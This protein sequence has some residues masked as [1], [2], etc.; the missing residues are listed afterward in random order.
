VRIKVFG[1]FGEQVGGIQGGVEGKE[2]FA[3]GGKTFLKD[4]FDEDAKAVFAAGGQK[5]DSAGG[6]QVEST[7]E[8]AS[9]LSGPFGDGADFT[10]E[11]AEE[12]ENLAGFRVVDFA[13]ANG[14]VLVFGH[15]ES[16]FGFLGK[17]SDFNFQAID[18]PGF[19][20]EDGKEE[21]FEF[22]GVAFFGDGS[23]TGE[24]ES[25]ESL[26]VLVFGEIQFELVVELIHM[27]AGIHFVNGIG[28]FDEFLFGG[29]FVF[30]F[31]FSDQLFDDVLNGDNTRRAAIFIQNNGNVDFLGLEIVEE[32]P[33]GF[34]FGNEEG[35]PDDFSKGR[36]AVGFVESLE[37]VFGVEHPDDGVDGLF[38]HG[39]AGMAVLQDEIDGFLEVVL[40]AEA[41]HFGAG[42]HN[43]I[44]SSVAEIEDGFNHVPL[45]LIDGAF[46]FL[47][48]DER[49][50]FL[51]PFLDAFFFGI[52]EGDSGEPPDNIF[53]TVHE[54][55][56]RV[57]EGVGQADGQIAAD[58]HGSAAVFGP[59][60]RDSHGEE[61]EKDGRDDKRFDER[62]PCFVGGKVVP[63]R[64]KIIGDAHEK[65]EVG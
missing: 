45:L 17:G 24:G 2:V 39:I 30:I 9:G 37:E 19:D 8:F 29:F 3:K 34:A 16:G 44:D 36:N 58:K 33:D 40:N 64:H 42:R 60:L 5:A 51:L 7:A 52:T 47:P 62:K 43:L 28:D 57:E 4:E 46:F 11:A 55:G 63:S 22:K 56:Q 31:D 10:V 61:Q 41:D 26:I 48:F 20:I 35:I 27:T 54:M 53:D 32:V 59:G 14:L 38:I 49:E 21:I 50:D 12:G 25:G 1:A 13:D 15:I 65:A 23:Q 18:F 6:E